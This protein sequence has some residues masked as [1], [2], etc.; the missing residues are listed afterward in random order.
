MAGTPLL[1]LLWRSCDRIVL[2]VAASHSLSKFENVVEDHQNTRVV[3]VI[4]AKIS[5]DGIAPTYWNTH[6][7]SFSG[8]NARPLAYLAL[9]GS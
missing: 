4:G 8:R 1:Q 5:N 2:V 3:A 7:D 6:S 9:A